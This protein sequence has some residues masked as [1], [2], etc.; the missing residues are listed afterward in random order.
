M[1]EAERLGNLFL[2][3]GWPKSKDEAAKCKD[4]VEEAQAE[5]A[6]EA[7]LKVLDKL[8]YEIRLTITRRDLDATERLKRIAEIVNKMG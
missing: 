7:R 3:Q 4:A 8:A 5:T 6:N 1:N 2:R